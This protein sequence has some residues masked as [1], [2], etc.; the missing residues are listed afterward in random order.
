MDLLS[1]NRLS[2]A[3]RRV[4][5]A[6]IA[7]GGGNVTALSRRLFVTYQCVA[8]HLASMYDKL[9]DDLGG[10]NT[11][12]ALA[13]WYFKTNFTMQIKEVARRIGA[14]CL[15]GL[16]CAYTFGGGDNDRMIRRVRRGRRTEYE[17]ITEKE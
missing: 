5:D 10:N 17:C 9:H 14:T 3:E 7:T 2:K 8:N 6:I 13:V 11:I 16:F 1:D 4:L 12:Q 15:L